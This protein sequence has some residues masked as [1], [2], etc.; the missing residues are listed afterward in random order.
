MG[1]GNGFDESPNKKKKKKCY[2]ERERWREQNR[3]MVIDGY[4]MGTWGAWVYVCMACCLSVVVDVDGWLFLL[5]CVACLI[6]QKEKKMFSF[7]CFCPSVCLLG[8]LRE[9]ERK[10]KS[11]KESKAEKRSVECL[12]V[13]QQ[14]SRV[15][16]FA[17]I[18]DPPSHAR[19]LLT[20]FSFT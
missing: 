12:S 8:W 15:C 18:K 20:S 9:K 11:N 2:E 13:C 17:P 4:D 14:G 1:V 7:W 19:P 10:S 16:V 3:G 5:A 6:E